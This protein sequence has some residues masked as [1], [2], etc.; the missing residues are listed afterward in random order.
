M[1]RST[2]RNTLENKDGYCVVLKHGS[3]VVRMP[4]DCST[5]LPFHLEVVNVSRKSLAM[6]VALFEP[7]ALL[8]YCIV[9]A[10]SMWS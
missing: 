7:S 3:F 6:P 5:P 2:R 4:T 9:Q 1:K 8:T 10:D